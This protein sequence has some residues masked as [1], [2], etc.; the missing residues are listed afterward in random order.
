LHGENHA[1]TADA[2]L[3]LG[4]ILS[5]EH[6]FQSAEEELRK[7]VSTLEE[8]FG[9]K[10]L[11]TVEAYSL[12]GTILNRQGGFEEALSLHEKALEARKEQLGVSHPDVKLSEAAVTANREGRHEDEIAF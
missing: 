3:K 12:L 5:L 4:H 10:H 8:L 2:R 6:E 11:R 7:A 9:A 1:D